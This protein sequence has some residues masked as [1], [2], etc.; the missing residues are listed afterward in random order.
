M[1]MKNRWNAS[2]R[3]ILLVMSMAITLL[4]M[5]CDEVG[6]IG[7]ISTESSLSGMEIHFI[8]VGQGDSSLIKLDD[9][10]N[11][12]I[13]GGSRSQSD[14][15]VAYLRDK[16]VERVDYLIAT[17]PHED[18]IGGLPTVIENFD[19]GKVYMPDVTHN[20]RIFETLL[21]TIE[22]KGLQV[23]VAKGYEKLISEDRLS[24]EILGPNSD[25]YGNLNDYSVVNRITYGDVSALF[26][27]DME[28]ASEYE[29]LELG[30]EIES[31]ILKVSH[32][33]SSSSTVE[34]FL[35]GVAPRYA[36]ISAGVDNSY[37]HP[38]RET[39]Q[40]LK[41][42]DVGI[43]R[44]DLDGDIMVTTDGVG[45]EVFKLSGSADTGNLESEPESG[46]DSFVANMNSKIYHDSSCN[47]LPNEENRIYFDSIEEAKR[48][49]YTP[50]SV[51][52]D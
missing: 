45:I 36:I 5:G 25:S 7:L 12:L 50:H 37:G 18:H 13:D 23:D 34:E 8:D 38:H 48:N 49:G 33:G 46:E 41:A 17:H 28:S 52:I 35:D 20:T 47:S 9:G 11:I 27:G 2:S 40:K 42:R 1:D 4:A 19:I 51:C 30:Y 10:R 44:T 39:L 21:K 3:L 15:L 6:E 43:L 26:T 29:V 14:K 24:F 31:D 16:G 32:H 22:S